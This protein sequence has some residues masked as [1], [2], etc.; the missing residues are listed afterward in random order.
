MKRTGCL[1]R[2]CD[3]FWRNKI[4]ALYEFRGLA[5]WQMTRQNQCQNDLGFLVCSFLIKSIVLVESSKIIW[6]YRES[7]CY[8]CK[9]LLG[10]IGFSKSK[11]SRQPIQ[12][13]ISV[14]KGQYSPSYTD[15]SDKDLYARV[16]AAE[17]PW[18]E[19]MIKCEVYGRIYA[20]NGVNTDPFW[21]WLRAPV[22]G[23]PFLSP[24]ASATTK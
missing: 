10:S 6:D 21:R 1:E 4:V 19:I 16:E 2:V 22:P 20:F 11:D 24:R 12:R 3:F 13:G 8:R 14:E 7:W 23:R 18:M 17:S 15:V 5:S 9:S